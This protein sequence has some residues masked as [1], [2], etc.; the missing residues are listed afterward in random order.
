MRGP[1]RVGYGAVTKGRTRM[2]AVLSTGA[3]LLVAGAVACQA[4]AVIIGI[5]STGIE[6]D[7]ASAPPTKGAPSVPGPNGPDANLGEPAQ[8]SDDA[9][10]RACLPDGGCPY[11]GKCEYPDDAACG[12]PGVC[13]SGAPPIV[14]P[15]GGSGVVDRLPRPEGY[16]ETPP[17][18]DGGGNVATPSARD[19][20]LDA[21]DALGD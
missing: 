9:G 12:T 7:D 11:E 4:G 20:D 13:V 19:A 15:G 18:C 1:G 17:V 14:H 8:T 2:R 10:L 3:A 21:E 16:T 6:S 5:E